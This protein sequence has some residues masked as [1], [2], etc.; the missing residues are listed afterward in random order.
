MKIFLLATFFTIS[1]FG[2]LN[3][4]EPVI[5]KESNSDLKT[6]KPMPV[7]HP[8]ITKDDGKRT[9]KITAA[10]EEPKKKS[11]P[12]VMIKEKI[13]EKPITTKEL[14]KKCKVLE[15]NN[16]PKIKHKKV[17][18]KI[19]HKT[20]K[21]F[22]PRV[23][24]VLP[25]VI[26]DSKKYSTTIKT[27]KKYKLIRYYLEQ[28][29]KKFVF[30]FK[31]KVYNYTKRRQ[32][33]APYFKSFIIGNHR[34]EGYFRVVIQGVKNLSRYKVFIKNNIIKISVK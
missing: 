1:L 24:K 33:N 30:D 25:F 3:P 12:I 31:A 8:I 22:I 21:K 9:V 2:R 6:L 29:E 20:V 17:V 19:K 15:K 14:I 10:Q 11:K 4:F 27:R 13:V 18:K 32:L 23:Y 28:D 26:I 7:K 5:K 34:E 16:I